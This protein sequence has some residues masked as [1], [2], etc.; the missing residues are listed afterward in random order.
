MKVKKKHFLTSLLFVIFICSALS[1]ILAV[2]SQ[3]PQTN[4]DVDATKAALTQ[5]TQQ[6]GIDNKIPLKNISEADKINIPESIQSPARI[7][8][9]IKNNENIEFSLFIILVAVFI[10]FCVFIYLILEV[11][12]IF[13]TGIKSGFA[14][15]II[16]LIISITGALNN[17]ALFLFGFSWFFKESNLLKLIIIIPILAIIIFGFS[18]LIGL[19]RERTQQERARIAGLKAGSGG[20]VK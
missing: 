9:G 15:L 17:F 13:G 19:I 3:T 12:P 16:A 20:L 10:M 8:F 11:I 4:P 2:D 14:A 5:A 1:I 6:I 18:K 7:I